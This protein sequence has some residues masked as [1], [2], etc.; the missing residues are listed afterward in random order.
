[1][2][3]MHSVTTWIKDSEPKKQ[4]SRI[5]EAYENKYMKNPTHLKMAMWAETCGETVRTNTIKL[6][7]KRKHNLQNPL[8]NTV[9][10]D[11]KI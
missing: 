8:N 11:A 2:E 7:R 6:A 5:L 9:Q 3:N 4:R 10:Q 1:M